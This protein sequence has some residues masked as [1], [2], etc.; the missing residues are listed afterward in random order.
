MKRYRLYQGKL[1]ENPD[2]E[3]VRHKDVQAIVDKPSKTVDGVPITPRMTVWVIFKGKPLAVVVESVGYS[4]DLENNPWGSGTVA[5]HEWFYST[6]QA[7]EAAKGKSDE[8]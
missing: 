5:P 6:R 4:I 1:R 7:A 3:W 2:G 8:S